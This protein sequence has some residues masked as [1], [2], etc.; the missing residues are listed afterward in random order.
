MFVTSKLIILIM[1]KPLEFNITIAAAPMQVWKIM[2]D[3]T[4]YRLWTAPWEGSSYIGDWSEGSEIRFVGEDGAGLL[5]RVAINRPGEYV[6]THLLGELGPGGVLNE[7]NSAM[8][9]DGKECYRYTA[10]A[11][12]CLLE[13]LLEAPGMPDEM[14]EYMAGT[15]PE[16]LKILKGLCEKGA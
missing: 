5:A 11:D 12:G 14:G 4:T 2:L 7:A 9:K 1:A 8:W 10:N 13:I 3:A 15:W 16:A 6:E